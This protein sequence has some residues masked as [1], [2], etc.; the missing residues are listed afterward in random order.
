MSFL[1]RLL[2]SLT[3]SSQLVL[4]GELFIPQL[5]LGRFKL[6]NFLPAALLMFLRI[7]LKL[8]QLIFLIIESLWEIFDSL[9]G[10]FDLFL[11]AQVL[12]QGG[13]QTIL[14]KL[15]HVFEWSG[16]GSYIVWLRALKLTIKFLLQSFRPEFVNE[17]HNVWL[18]GHG[19]IFGGIPSLLSFK[20]A[21]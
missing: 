16:K 9:A 4:H 6:L 5:A 14:P 19:V 3:P 17:L 11:H 15:L 13:T 10:S 1:A 7:F 12:F 2:D 8:F 20:I 18:H 21:I